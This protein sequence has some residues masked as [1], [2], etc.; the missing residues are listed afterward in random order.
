MDVL[1]FSEEVKLKLE[2]DLKQFK[3]FFKKNVHRMMWFELF[4]EMTD[5]LVYI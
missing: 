3:S 1:P 4:H 2:L 5:L